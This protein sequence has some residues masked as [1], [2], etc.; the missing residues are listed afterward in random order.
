[1]EVGYYENLLAVNRFNSQLWEVYLNRPLDWFNMQDVGSVRPTGDFLYRELPPSQEFHAS[2]VLVRTNRWGMRDREYEKECPPGV[3][4]I[5]M[6]GSSWTMGMGVDQDSSFEA[7]LEQLLNQ[8]STDGTHVRYEVLNFGVPGYSAA[9]HLAILDKRALSFG[10]H[11]V[12]YDPF[13]AGTLTSRFLV[14]TVLR[15]T[16]IPYEGLRDIIQKAGIRQEMSEPVALQRLAPYRQDITVALLQLMAD[17]CRKQGAIPALLNL[18]ESSSNS[19]TERNEILQL[20]Q[21]AGFILLDLSDWSAQHHRDDLRLAKWD[22]HPNALGHKIIAEHLYE[23]LM[24]I[25]DQIGLSPANNP[26]PNKSPA[27]RQRKLGLASM[28][29]VGGVCYLN[30]IGPLLWRSGAGLCQRGDFRGLLSSCQRPRKLAGRDRFRAAPES[31][32]AIEIDD[33]S[34]FSNMLRLYYWAISTTET[35]VL[36]WPVVS[37]TFSSYSQYERVMVA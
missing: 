18:S 12:I 36:R 35:A 22:G 1:M 27:G 3:I 34:C 5:A 17:T 33:N 37:P 8:K 19:P 26:P 15:G 28:R 7:V 16:E 13:G 11:I 10:P 32:P 30:A 2:G 20:A 21:A 24:E 6:I 25:G 23:K 14:R 4:R 9:Q 29:T 31:T